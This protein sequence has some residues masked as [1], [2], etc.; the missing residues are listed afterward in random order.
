MHQLLRVWKKAVV[1]FPNL[2]P[3]WH[4]QQTVS[5]SSFLICCYFRSL[6][7]K[8]IQVKPKEEL[9]Y[10]FIE[11]QK[12]HCSTHDL[13]HSHVCIFVSKRS[14]P[15]TSAQFAHW[16]NSWSGSEAKRYNVTVIHSSCIIRCLL[17]RQYY[18]LR[19]V[20]TAV[21]PVAGNVMQKNHFF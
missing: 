2:L 5:P 18:W 14:K 1:A 3:D 10:F 20:C 19:N 16:T 7:P 6:F 12:K 4:F 11:N 21:T 9:G 8:T 15:N 13:L 17:I